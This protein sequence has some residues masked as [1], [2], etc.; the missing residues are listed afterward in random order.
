MATLDSPGLPMGRSWAVPLS[1]GSPVDDAGPRS[2]RPGGARRRRPRRPDVG[3]RPTA[4]KGRSA[5]WRVGH[6]A[7]DDRAGAASVDG[8]PLEIGVSLVRQRNGAALTQRL[9]AAAA[10]LTGAAHAAVV[11]HTADGRVAQVVRH[12]AGGARDSDES[13]LPPAVAPRTVPTQTTQAGLAPGHSPVPAP[14]RRFVKAHFVGPG[15]LASVLYAGDKHSGRFSA[16]D[17]RRL[18]A[19]A[20]L[21]EVAVGWQGQ[22][23]RE[24]ERAATAT[25]PGTPNAAEHGRQPILRQV[26][27]A[28]EAERARVARDLHDEVGQALT[29][30]L[31]GLHLVDTALTSDPVDADRAA[32]RAA[33]VRALVADAL[34]GVRRMAFDLRPTVLDDLGLLAAVERLG[35]DLHERHG[36][37]VEVQVEG[38]TA[39]DRLP[40]PVETVVYRVVQ[41]SLTNV[42]RHAHASTV[43]V[44]LQG[45]QHRV[46]ALVRDDGVGFD[47]SAATRTLGLR[48]MAERADLAGGAVRLRSS[49]GLGCTVELEV[50]LG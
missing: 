37:R 13:A 40:G 43:R 47:V 4:L 22:L 3:V 21:A 5:E 16:A 35:D 17:Q 12:R 27:D 36:L 9:L 23:E 1:A 46:R 48:G 50:P 20:A 45:D 39:E 11:V 14:P 8:V 29:S 33:E 6:D 30:V 41:E 2:G 24:Q 15:G 7:A 32:A 28:Q 49:P 26:I 42:V 34:R 31:L 18:T 38:L 25:E 44:F 19:L 10:E